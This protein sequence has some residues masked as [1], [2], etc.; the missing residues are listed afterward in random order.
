MDAQ[1][2]EETEMDN[3]DSSEATTAHKHMSHPVVSGLQ[4]AP[5]TSSSQVERKE[6]TMPFGVHL[7]RN[8]VLYRAAQVPRICHLPFDDSDNLMLPNSL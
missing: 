2:K 7:W 3:S 8:P 1:L 4:H 6:K 5:P